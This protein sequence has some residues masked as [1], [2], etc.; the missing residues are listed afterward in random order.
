[1]RMFQSKP[2]LL[3][4]FLVLLPLQPV[5]AQ[6]N[7]SVTLNNYTIH[8]LNIYVKSVDYYGYSQWKKIEEIGPRSYIMLRSVPDGTVFGA[9]SDEKDVS[10]QPVTVRYS[11]AIKE[12]VINFR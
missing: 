2:F 7:G 8:K 11:G 1:M 10:Y 6:E 3:A 9:E 12:F 5:L 4:V